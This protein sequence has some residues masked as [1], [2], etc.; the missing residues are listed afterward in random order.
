M[1]KLKTFPKELEQK[2]EEI[3]A[4]L[5]YGDKGKVAKRSNK[6]LEYV[7]MVLGKKAFNMQVLEM[8]IEVMNENK[9]RLEIKPSMKVA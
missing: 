5:F 7:G 4:W 8:A 6:S 3:N 1:A 9:N 2:V